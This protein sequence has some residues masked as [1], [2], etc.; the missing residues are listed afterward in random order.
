MNRIMFWSG[1]SY[2]SLEDCM[3]RSV[4]ALT[5]I[6]SVIVGLHD[7]KTYRLRYRIEVNAAWQTLQCDILAEVDGQLQNYSFRNLGN[8]QWTMNEVHQPEFDG[9]TEVDISLT[10]L[11]NTLPINRLRLKV[12]DEAEIN[13]ICIDILKQE[14]KAVRQKYRKLSAEEYRF[15]NIPN[16]FKAI[17]KVNSQ[18]FV[19]DYP[20]L[21]VLT[22]SK[23]L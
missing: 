17:I 14:V 7:G 16:D 12:T 21:F 23:Y 18:G 9:C 8:N 19:T 15:E 20:P 2:N 22:F 11:T 13:A 6:S 10:P 5:M 4:G 1:K 3:I